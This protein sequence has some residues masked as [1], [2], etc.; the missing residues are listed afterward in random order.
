MKGNNIEKINAKISKEESKLSALKLRKDEIMRDIQKTEKTLENLRSE[1]QLE[2][3][4]NF[5]VLVKNNNMTVSDI[6]TAMINKDFLTLQEKI[7]QTI[8]ENSTSEYT[9]TNDEGDLM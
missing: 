1:V 8:E 2:E 3:M 7:E 5:L 9:Q 4:K 6:Q